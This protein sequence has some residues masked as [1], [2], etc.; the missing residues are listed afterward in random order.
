MKVDAAHA[1]LFRDLIEAAATE[2]GQAESVLFGFEA[3]AAFYP[4][5][6]FDE[7][8]RRATRAGS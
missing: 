3:F 6:I 1:K 2:L 8:F 5:A 7:A 4:E